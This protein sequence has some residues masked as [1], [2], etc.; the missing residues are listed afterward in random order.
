[1]KACLF[2]LT[3]AGMVA[4][5]CRA[6]IKSA[7]VSADMK[8]VADWQLANPSPRHVADWVQAPFYLGLLE[9]Y[10]VSGDR[11][12]LD[13]V[14]T[15]GDKSA[16]TAAPRKNDVATHADDHAV[17]A[18][19]IAYDEIAGTS[20]GTMNAQ[21]HFAKVRD[22]L[23]AQ[24]AASLSGGTFTW[25]WC[26]ALFMAPP[27]WVHL[28][29][30][31]QDQRFLAF[32]DKEWWT[33]TEVL[34]DPT[35]NLYYRDN[36]YFKQRGANG[37]KIFWSRGNGWVA[38]GLTRVLD[39]LP[40]DHPSRTKYLA[41]YRVMMESLVK[42]QAA[43]GLWKS[44]LLEPEAGAGESSGTAF[45]V[46]ALAWGLNRGL[47]D[48]KFF[49]RPMEKGWAALRKNIQPNGSLGHVQMIAEAPGAAGPE[50]HEVYGS[51]AFLL[52]GAEVLRSVEYS[53]RRKDLVDF[54]GLKPAEKFLREQPA[55]AARYVPE[56][57]DDFA[58][59]NDLVAFRAYG[60][61]IRSGPEDSGFDAW[62][63]RVTYPVMDKWYIEDVTKLPHSNEAKS[64]HKDHGEGYDAYKVGDSRGCGGIGLW[65]GSELHKSD[66]Y[67]AQR[68]IERSSTRV[69][70]ELDF[71]SEMDGKKVRETKRVTLPMGSRLFQVESRFTVD[72]KP[73]EFPVAIGLKYQ[74]AGSQGKG[75]A[76]RG[77]AVV[78]E[79][80]NGE[81]LGQGVVLAPSSITEFR[82][83]KDEKGEGQF[84]VIAKTDKTGY[85][86]WFA[87]YGWEG[88]GVIKSEADWNEYLAKFSRKVAQKPFSDSRVTLKVRE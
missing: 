10:R 32:S 86:R 82:E 62:L 52:A 76:G 7:E 84:L 36:R 20:R 17:F 12:F 1:M 77:I 24:P 35:E 54:S 43:D 68:V 41:L 5:F 34:F 50:S 44:G 11:K 8:R 72:G 67:V 26:D 65:N 88:L 37:T 78:S 19:W 4:P 75:D 15:A 16:W 74:I 61:A 57:M 9:L 83:E 60:P 3:A 58:F 31:T 55:V 45:F 22:A 38:S 23:K 27:V 70:F 85:I 42:K 81:Y 53:K 33:T 6:E 21:A 47:L 30:I 59:E 69:V 87:G 46:Q 80:L 49:A 28:S 79:Q 39:H 51:G 13:A 18:A 56:R 48:R 73:A 29:S 63:K 25:C 71:A 64:Y 2:L 66:T 14:R 40:A